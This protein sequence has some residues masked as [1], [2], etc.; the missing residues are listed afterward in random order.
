MRGNG[1]IMRYTLL[2]VFSLCSTFLTIFAGSWVI[3]VVDD[4][5][6]LTLFYLVAGSAIWALISVIAKKLRLVY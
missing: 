2:L 6:V 4:V 3:R 1:W 5:F